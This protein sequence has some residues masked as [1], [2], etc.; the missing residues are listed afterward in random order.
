VKDGVP[1][2]PLWLADDMSIITTNSNLLAFRNNINEIF[3]EINEW[4]QGSLFA[5][6]YGKIFFFQFVTKNKKATRYPNIFWRQTH[7]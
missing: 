4:F 5:L 7:Y 6:N 1:S 3:T 2:N